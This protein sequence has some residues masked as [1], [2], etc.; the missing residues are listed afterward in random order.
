MVKF[1]R[2]A[3]LPFTVFV[4]GACVLIVEIVA[5]RILAPYFGNTIYSV[6]S[7]ISVVLAALSLGYWVG[8]RMADRY[9]VKQLFFA[10]VAFS[11]VLVLFIKVLQDAILPA[12]GFSLPLTTGPLIASAVLFFAPSFVMGLLSPFAVALHQREAKIKGVGT[13]A[14]QI[15]FFSTVGSILGSLLAGFVLIPYLGIATILV[16]V[17]VLLVLMGM[18]PVV[19]IG[20]EKRFTIAAFVLSGSMLILVL[21]GS[22]NSNTLYSHDGVYERITIFDGTYHGRPTRFLMQD[23]S[24][25][26]AMYLDGDDLT[27]DYTKYYTLHSIFVSKLNRALMLGGGAYSVPK[28]LMTDLS[29]VKVDVSEI[30]PSLIPLSKKYFDLKDSPRLTHYIEDGRR[31]LHDT[32]NRYD[33]I[34]SDVYHSIYSVPAHF[35]TREFMELASSRLT[36]DGV[37]IA[38]LIGSTS[39]EGPSFIWSEIRTMQQVFPEVYIFGVSSPDSAETQNIIV[40]GSKSEVRKDMY[41]PSLRRSAYQAVREA[42]GH[43]LDHSHIDLRSYRVLTDDYAPVDYLTSKI[44]P[45]R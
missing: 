28:A 17:G 11:G 20:I 6:S 40:V 10:L 26:A 44:L 4:T 38:N 23:A 35:T 12:Y 25:S 22:T 39:T 5:I 16:G 33:L 3:L 19:W 9:P 34:F 8:G 30:E 21:A 43:Y 42:A 36:D 13:A 31:M 24:N 15:F 45:K 27:F 41:D 32:S 7:V 18:L 2:R 14:G 1:L 37:F 29:D